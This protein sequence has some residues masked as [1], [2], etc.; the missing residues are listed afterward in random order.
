LRKAGVKDVFVEPL[1]KDPDTQKLLNDYQKQLTSPG[2]SNEAIQQL[3]DQI[4]KRIGIGFGRS[5]SDHS[6]LTDAEKKSVDGIMH[7]IDTAAKLGMHV[8]G[9]EP[10]GSNPPNP[11]AATELMSKNVEALKSWFNSNNPDEVRNAEKT[12]EQTLAKYPDSATEMKAWLQ[13]LKDGG[14]HPGDNPGMSFKDYRDSS[15]V[16]AVADLLD[17]DPQAKAA[18]FAGAFHF[19]HRIREPGGLPRN[20][21]SDELQRDRQYETVDVKYSGGDEKRNPDHWRSPD[22]TAADKNLLQKQ[23]FIYRYPGNSFDYTVH[24]PE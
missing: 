2:T 11:Q 23:R 15:W 12:I 8:H 5:P 22:T 6:P 3:R 24:L 14:F 20:T 16:N 17:K 1:G 10:K 21:F 13:Q 19:G 18:V 9:L 7:L 4:E